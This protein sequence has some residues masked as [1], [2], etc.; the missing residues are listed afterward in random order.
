MTALRN[1]NWWLAILCLAALPT[2]ARAEAIRYEFFAAPTS[3]LTGYFI[4]DRETTTLSDYQL[5]FDPITYPISVFHPPVTSLLSATTDSFSFSDATEASGGGVTYSVTLTNFRLRF[6]DHSLG[7]GDGQPSHELIGIYDTPGGLLHYSSPIG[8]AAGA[9][10]GHF[11]SAGPV[12]TAV[13]EPEVWALIA[14]GLGLL[15]VARRHR[16]PALA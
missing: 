13:P 6:L 15:G 1:A 3:Q 2:L 9:L 4:Y 14:A 7:P 11:Y 10:F 8:G 12:V 16:K 5:T